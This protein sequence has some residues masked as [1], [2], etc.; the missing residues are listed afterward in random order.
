MFGFFRKMNQSGKGNKQAARDINEQNIYIS[1]YQQQ[2]IDWDSYNNLCREL[3]TEN[4]YGELGYTLENTYI[5][6]EGI[7]IKL[8]FVQD[9][10]MKTSNLDYVEYK[11][12]DTLK[13][14]TVLDY[15][16]IRNKVLFL[17]GN[18]GTGK[19]STLKM[20][21]SKKLG[22]TGSYQPILVFLNQLIY[23]NESF[24]VLLNRY[25]QAEINV[26]LSS[27]REQVVLL[28]D[29]F[30]E[31]KMQSI[32]TKKQ[33]FREIIGLTRYKNISIVFVTRK[34]CLLQEL[35]DLSDYQ[36]FEIL[37]YTDRDIQKWLNK[38]NEIHPCTKISIDS[39]KQRKLFELCHSKLLLY[40]IIKIYESELKI[41]STFS[42]ETI[43]RYLILSST[44]ERYSKNNYN[45]TDFNDRTPLELK[46]R[47]YIFYR[48][49][50]H[51]TNSHKW[52]NMEMLNMDN[53]NELYRENDLRI[54]FKN[55]EPIK[56]ED[57]YKHFYIIKGGSS[58][59]SF[60]FS[61]DT[62]QA[63]LCAEFIL[64]SL[65]YHSEN[66]HYC[67]KRIVRSKV[68][69]LLFYYFLDKLFAG[70]SK[71]KLII[72]L[73]LSLNECNRFSDTDYYMIFIIIYN[74]LFNFLYRKNMITISEKEESLSSLD[75]LFDHYFFSDTVLKDNY[76]YMNIVY[77][78]ED[79]I[80]L[81]TYYFQN[82]KIECGILKNSSEY[83]LYLTFE[84][85]KF[86][87]VIFENIMFN[88]SSQFNN[89]QFVNCRF[90]ECVFETSAD[91]GSINFE[92]TSFVNVYICI[93]E[94]YE[95]FNNCQCSFL[96]K[97]W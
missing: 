97:N 81:R 19:T 15:F 46:F 18:Y 4:L 33:L 12:D 89:V 10:I 9:E 22:P 23:H 61:Y 7:G 95:L 17:E 25:L 54:K 72:F 73:G 58:D 68:E 56:K 96:W 57:M 71:D 49:S 64:Y 76:R 80:R 11:T 31:V 35:H 53:A 60:K 29:E 26:K 65:E 92:D 75:L 34:A 87:D 45:L 27:I 94:K 63:F 41:G 2:S 1:S 66:W 91:T 28:F 93:Q 32:E 21:T 52:I 77:N 50:P 70:Y 24:E 30:D 20:L 79:F 90:V 44:G 48:K 16:K 82:L 59:F 5:S 74:L 40:K 78:S 62:F 51:L 86:N 36:T 55:K 69:L 37:D 6:T 14:L 42:D 39:L 3:I 67:V 88:C 84:D 43:F 38:W 8:D 13:Y 83:N 47:A 85:S